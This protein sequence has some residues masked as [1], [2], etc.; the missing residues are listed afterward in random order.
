MRALTQFPLALGIALL[1]A[2]APAPG[3]GSDTLKKLPT[4]A[5]TWEK[6]RHLLARA[7]FSGT[8][9]EV[10]RLYRM[11][12]PQ[13]VDHLLDCSLSEKQKAEDELEALIDGVGSGLAA[14]SNKGAGPTLDALVDTA[15]WEKFYNEN[16]IV[17]DENHPL[18]AF[19]RLHMIKLLTTGKDGKPLPGRRSLVN[20]GWIMETMRTRWMEELLTSQAPLEEKLVLFWHGHFTSDFSTVEDGYM[21]YLQNHL[22]RRHALGNYGELLHAIVHDP[23]MLRYLDNNTNV[24]GNPNENLAREIME[25]FS[26]GEGNGYSEQDIKEGARALTGNKYDSKNKG[27]FYFDRKNHDFDQKT[28]LG[29]TGNYNADHFADL[30]LLQPATSRFMAAKIFAFFAYQDPDPAIIETLA[31]NFRENRFE[32]K[33]LLREVFLSE[34][35]YSRKSIGA[36]IKSPTQLIAGTFRK[37]GLKRG[38]Y[39]A[40]VKASTLMGQALYQPPNVKGWD[41]DRAWINASR[42]FARQNFSGYLVEGKDT[43]FSNGRSIGTTRNGSNS[44][45]GVDLVAS[46]AGLEFENST[47][48]VDHFLRS[49]FAVPI[50]DPKRQKLINFL[51]QGAPLPSSTQWGR[52]K[53]TINERLQG[54]IVLMMSMPEYQLC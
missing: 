11:G 27:L 54:V 21:L 16:T 40:M 26:M 1:T 13:A 41:G 31:R 48:V 37:L 30:I 22:F 44:S 32:I 14:A 28:I 46:L 3:A 34:T 33:P 18:A 17:A 42:L 6:A 36:Q 23:A 20:E 53:T 25:L 29:H 47:E 19:S 43:L 24:K 12:L 52:R 7:G 45:R 2:T 4:S 35:F 39:A 50:A 10:S 49:L 15:D 8:S 5:W 9:A 51:D 38:D